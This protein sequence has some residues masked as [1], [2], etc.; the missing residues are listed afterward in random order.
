MAGAGSPPELLTFNPA[1]DLDELIRTVIEGDPEEHHD[2]LVEL[3]KFGGNP[4]VVDR[5]VE[6]LRAAYLHL[7]ESDE[8]RAAHREN[9]IIWLGALEPKIKLD[10]TLLY[11][12]QYERLPG[13][14]TEAA[15][16]WKQRRFAM[17]KIRFHYLPRLRNHRENHLLARDLAHAIGAKKFDD[18]EVRI[19]LHE[20]TLDGRP[21]VKVAAAAALIQLGYRETSYIDVLCRYA[22]AAKSPPLRWEAIRGL[23]EA[24]VPATYA[25]LADKGWKALIRELDDAHSELDQRGQR[26]VHDLRAELSLSTQERAVSD[27][28]PDDSY[29]CIFPIAKYAHLRPRKPRS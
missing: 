12:L 4:V 2:S 18:P 21:S 9:V 19:Q 25:R 14:L 15:I 5:V 28:G 3:S 23:V 11:V 17:D 20:M 13:P 26:F 1:V 8:V 29:A 16:L 27:S 10:T 7:D 6:E 24:G 22:V